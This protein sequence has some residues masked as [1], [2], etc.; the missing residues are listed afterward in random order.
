[1][2]TDTKFKKNWEGEE[3]QTSDFRDVSCA[4]F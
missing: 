2:A 4:P 1:M 3:Q